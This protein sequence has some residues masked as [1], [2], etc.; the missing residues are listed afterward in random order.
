ME[1]GSELLEVR[2]TRQERH[3]HGHR[4]DHSTA[5]EDRDTLLVGHV[6]P[7]EVEILARKHKRFKAT[8]ELLQAKVEESWGETTM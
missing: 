1:R 5:Q 2:F 3:V 6:Y 7:Q 8:T 4:A